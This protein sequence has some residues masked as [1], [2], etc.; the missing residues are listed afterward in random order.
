MKPAQMKGYRNSKI[1]ETNRNSAEPNDPFELKAFVKVKR[2]CVDLQDWKNFEG[3]T[4]QIV[5]LISQPMLE[6]DFSGIIDKRSD[7][8]SGT[9]QHDEVYRQSLIKSGGARAFTEMALAN[10]D[11]IREKPKSLS[12]Q[13]AADLRIVVIGARLY[14]GS[15]LHM[16]HGTRLVGSDLGDLG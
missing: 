7:C 13:E 10:A 16:L 11:N 12:C 15:R 5:S 2:A 4:P 9:K 1:V 3:Y 6:K 8:V 14:N